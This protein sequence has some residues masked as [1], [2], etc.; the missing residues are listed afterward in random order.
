MIFNLVSWKGKH[1]V[2]LGSHHSRYIKGGEDDGACMKQM[3][4]ERL[5]ERKRR[6]VILSLFGFQKVFNNR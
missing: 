1:F 3:R 6:Q 5:R 2:L 4:R